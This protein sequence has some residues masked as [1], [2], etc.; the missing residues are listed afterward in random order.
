MPEKPSYDARTALIVV[1][2]QNDFADPAGSLYVA[3]GEQ[4]V[5]LINEEIVRARE[6]PARRT[7]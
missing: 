2:V 7:P 6:A 3:G 1:D 4:V 5:P